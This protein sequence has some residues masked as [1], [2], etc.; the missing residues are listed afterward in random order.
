MNT[1]ILFSKIHLQGFVKHPDSEKA[2]KKKN[3]SASSGMSVR[4]LLS[5]VN[6]GSQVMLQS[7]CFH[8][9]LSHPSGT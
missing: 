9:L 1:A 2:K 5:I 3:S 6:S 4:K 7:P 8:L